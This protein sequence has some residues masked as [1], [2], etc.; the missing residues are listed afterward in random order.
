MTLLAV[1]TGGVMAAEQTDESQAIDFGEV[2][3]DIVEAETDTVEPDTDETVTEADETITIDRDE[4]EVESDESDGP[5]TLE[6]NLVENDDDASESVE[7]TTIDLDEWDTQKKPIEEIG[8]DSFSFSG[9]IEPGESNMHGSF[10][11][12][13]GDRIEIPIRWTPGDQDITVGIVDLDQGEGP[14]EVVSHG[15]DTAEVTVPED[16]DEWR[17]AIVNLDENTDTLSYSG[18]VET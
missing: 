4:W 13:E 1:A 6:I 15:A 16:S 11:W 8:P 12:S 17:V 14:G 5:D 2:E 9:E 18:S 7:P 3:T 10:T